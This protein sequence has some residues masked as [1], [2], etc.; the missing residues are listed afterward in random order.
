M[1]NTIYFEII[2]FLLNSRCGISSDVFEAIKPRKYI[3]MGFTDNDNA[4]NLDDGI[5]LKEWK[6][7]LTS[8]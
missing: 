5:Y 1:T 3:L 8:R 2:K 6:I 7:S 4:H